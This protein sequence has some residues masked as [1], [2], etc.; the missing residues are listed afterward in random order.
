MGAV[1]LVR[2]DNSK[3]GMSVTNLSFDPTKEAILRASSLRNA[4]L[5][6]N[7][8]AVLLLAFFNVSPFSSLA[9]DSRTAPDAPINSSRA[10]GIGNKS[11]GSGYRFL[12]V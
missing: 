4:R 5:R 12:A 3:P 9:Y 8:G 7:E 1:G 11:E 10:R 6:S 2:R